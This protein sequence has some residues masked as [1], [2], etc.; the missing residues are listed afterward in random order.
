MNNDQIVQVAIRIEKEILRLN[1]AVYEAVTD[2]TPK[3]EIT[4][5]I[6][7]SHNVMS[8]YYELLA[9]LK[10]GKRESLLKLQFYVDHIRTNLTMI[11]EN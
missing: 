4:D 1:D 2:K 10:G 11:E 7:R 6:T 3:H 9:Q 5:L 8:E